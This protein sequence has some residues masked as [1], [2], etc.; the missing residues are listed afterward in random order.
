VVNNGKEKPVSPY[1]RTTEIKVVKE[2]S[3]SAI[4]D[5]LI[6]GYY[7]LYHEKDEVI[8]ELYSEAE[9]YIL[10]DLM[11]V[12]VFSWGNGFKQYYALLT[13][14]LRKDGFVWIMKLTR[15]KLVYQHLM[16]VSEPIP[17]KPPTPVTLPPIEAML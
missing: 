15:T 9:R 17:K 5:F 3:A 13:P 10:R 1:S 7:E 4:D 12:A 6:E 11:G 14:I 2:I 16:D 8:S